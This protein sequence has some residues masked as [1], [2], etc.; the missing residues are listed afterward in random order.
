MMSV[1]KMRKPRQPFRGLL[2]LRLHGAFWLLVSIQNVGRFGSTTLNELEPLMTTQNRNIARV[3]FSFSADEVT[4]ALAQDYARH[5]RQ[6][7]AALFDIELPAVQVTV[8]ERLPDGAPFVLTCYTPNGKSDA[9]SMVTAARVVLPSF[10]DLKKRSAD[11][12]WAAALWNPGESLEQ[13]LAA[14]FSISKGYHRGKGPGTLEVGQREWLE[15]TAQ[16]CS[17]LVNSVDNFTNEELAYIVHA[18]L[19]AQLEALAA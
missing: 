17:A 16:R 13:D 1:S 15:R 5:S 6:A 14:L 11:Y 2:F 7:L 8:R 12:Y 3:H 9:P 10:L 4:P 19:S 18:E